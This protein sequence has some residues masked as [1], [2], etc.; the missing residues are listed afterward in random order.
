MSSIRLAKKVGVL[1]NE[2]KK[3]IRLNGCDDC[4]LEKK[5]HGAR[6]SCI[7]PYAFCAIVIDG[8]VTGTY[9]I[10]KIGDL[11]K[12]DSV[13]LEETDQVRLFHFSVAS[14]RHIT[15]IFSFVSDALCDCKLVGA[16]NH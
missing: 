15:F 10:A 9:V 8:K 3:L 4:S 1:E 14:V 11:T 2:Y 7:R 6:N 13:M 12:V 16:G 5:K